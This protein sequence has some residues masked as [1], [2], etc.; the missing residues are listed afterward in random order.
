MPRTRRTVA[1]RSRLQGRL[2]LE[3]LTWRASAPIDEGV[4]TSVPGLSAG[5]PGRSAIGEVR[6]LLRQLCDFGRPHRHVGPAGTD[7]VIYD[8]GGPFDRPFRPAGMSNSDKNQATTR[9]MSGAYPSARGGKPVPPDFAAD[10]AA[11]LP[12]TQPDR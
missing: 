6:L 8:V 5:L 12:K 3:P 4:R 7:G 1:S 11:M 2:S 10:N 9:R